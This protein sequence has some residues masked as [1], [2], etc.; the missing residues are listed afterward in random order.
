MMKKI[1]VVNTK[2]KIFGGEDSNIL[3]ELSFLRR[4]YNVKYLEFDNSEKFS[5]SDLISVF[6]LNNWNSNNLLKNTIANFNP[7]YVYIHNTWFKANLGI[8][9]ILEK[10]GIKTIIKLH[11]FR[12]ACTN[13]YFSKK[14]FGKNN[15]CPRCGLKRSRFTIFNK[16]FSN[17]MLK[18]I[19]VIRYGIRYF[20]ILK[21]SNFKLVVLNDF[22]KNYLLKEGIEASKLFL[23]YNPMSKKS[24][25]KYNP[26]SNYVVYAGGIN[27]EKGVPELLN[28]WINSETDL[29]LY[30]FG[31]GTIYKEL[32]EKYKNKNIKFFGFMS[33]E[34]VI[35]Y[36]SKSR[37]V[38]T[39]TKMYEGQPRLLTE[40]SIL[41][42]PSIYPSHGG[43]DEYF[44]KNYRFSFNQ[45][46]YQDLSQKIVLLSDTNLTK[47][48]SK[49]SHEHIKKMLD[50]ELLQYNLQSIL[51]SNDD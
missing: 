12:F 3:E 11:N 2:Y 35:D 47:N 40:A 16:Y 29:E 39:A 33:N 31:T 30:L 45:F 8:F 9:K 20:K 7:D 21:N 15:F 42:V 44:P 17:S 27:Y 5:L 50:Y 19:F 6:T 46:N 13:T 37:A 24:K 25:N 28:S 4:N 10:S 38:V 48:E 23:N 43:M 22:Y 14:H 36:I 49:R 18:S 51:N 41:N 1:L 26:N 32:V 34:E